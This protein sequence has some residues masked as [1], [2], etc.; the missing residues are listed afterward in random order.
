ME[1]HPKGRVMVLLWSLMFHDI[2]LVPTILWSNESDEKSRC[3]QSDSIVS[4]LA[5]DSELVSPKNPKE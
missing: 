4:V 3:S 1:K 2:Y 5:D